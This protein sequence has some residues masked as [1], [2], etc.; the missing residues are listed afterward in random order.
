[1][2]APQKK[3]AIM[4]LVKAQKCSQRQ[5]CRF[6]GLSRSSAR[7]QARTREDEAELV[8]LTCSR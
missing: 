6:I 1:V 2:S 4:Y 5:A 7:Y 8:E 3:A